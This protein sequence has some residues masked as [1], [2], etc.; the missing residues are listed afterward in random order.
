MPQGNDSAGTF[1]LARRGFPALLLSGLLTACLGAVLP[2]WRHHIAPDFVL[3]GTLFLCQNAGLIV[4]PVAGNPLIRRFGI[5]TGLMLGAILGTSGFALLAFFSPPAPPYWQMAGLFL[6]GLGAG[7]LNTGA[8]HAITPA[9][10]IEPAVTL[11]LGGA[12][13]NLG[14]FLTALVVATT[15]FTYTVGSTLLLLALPPAIAAIL[16]GRTRMPPGPAPR[17][18][19][20]SQAMA[21]FKSPAAVLFALLLFFQFGNEGAFTGW[22][23][24]F[25]IQ[26]L[27][28]S[29]VTS[30][31][32]LALFWLSLLV[33]RV[34]GQWLLPRVRHGRLLAGSTIAPLFACLIL[35]LTD[36]LFGAVTGVLLAAGGFALILPL[37]AERIGHRFPYFHPGFFNGIFS[38]GLTGGLLAPASLGYFAHWLGIGVIMGLPLIGSVM[39]FILHLILVLES[40]ISGRVLPSTSA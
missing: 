7:L 24:L 3:I 1:A 36:N 4:G 33:G 10:E 39:V 27:G 14:G 18:P 40:K 12:L 8:S 19:S 23:A 17:Q 38:L 25:L 32:L 9:Y 22:L 5:A 11:N 20:W 21:D 34:A 16:Y 37:V 28:A 26:K 35:S 29:P 31:M 13:F 2:G 6:V 30:L 15:F